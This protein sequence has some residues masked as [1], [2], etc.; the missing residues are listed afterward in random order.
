MA[1]AQQLPHLNKPLRHDVDGPLPAGTA[2]AA[3]RG[4]IRLHARTKV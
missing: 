2:A 3:G 4:G 1:D